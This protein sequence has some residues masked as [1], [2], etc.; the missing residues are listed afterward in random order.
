MRVAV[1]WNYGTPLRQ[2]SFRFEEYVRGLEALGHEAFVAC[3]ESSNDGFPV[4]IVSP[5]AGG[6]LED[7]GF[8]RGLEAD[9]AIVPSFHQMSDLLELIR[10]AGVR[11]I[12]M[13]DSDGQMGLRAFPLATLRRKVFSGSSDR[14]H[15]LRQLRFLARRYLLSFRRTDPQDAEFVRSAGSSDVLILGC[16]EARSHFRRFLRTAGAD[17][18]EDRVHVSPLAI[19]RVYCE[20]SD[21]GR[22]RRGIVAI[23]RWDDPQ[24]NAPLL[25]RALSRYLGRAGGEEA[26]DPV[27]IFGPGGE[28]RFGALSRRFPNVVYEGP[29]Y[30]EVLADALAGSRFILF[31][32][33]W[34]GAPHA[35]CE[36]LSMGATVVGTPIPSL[37]SWSEGGAYGRVASAHRAGPLAAAIAEEQ[38]AWRR[39]ER[40]PA[41]IASVWRRRSSG[42][43]V[44]QTM[45]EALPA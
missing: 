33:R 22:D 19:H 29:R 17:R 27:R 30:P 35:G 9:V 42:R 3:P 5:P 34:E 21:L 2:C 43:G 23:G 4:P 15:Q 18:L 1:V 6:G 16:E 26:G 13:G 28:D 7:A 24:K 11:T 39:G 38:A 41:S 25:V 20:S 44:C 14:G 37:R 12:A 45:L 8:W 40:D 32:S 10:G 31:S 36:A